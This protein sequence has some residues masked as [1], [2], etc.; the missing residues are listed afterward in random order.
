MKKI[1]YRKPKISKSK[2]AVKFFNRSRY[3]DTRSP[4][5]LVKEPEC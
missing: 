4:I 3:M 1:D 2:V 5:Y